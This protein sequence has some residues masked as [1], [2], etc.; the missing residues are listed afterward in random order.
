MRSSLARTAC[1]LL[2]A[3]GGAAVA[4]QLEVAPIMLDLPP[5][6]A[7][8]VL[9]VKNRGGEPVGIQVR[10]FAW[11]QAVENDN[12]DPHQGLADQSGPSRSSH[13]AKRKQYASS[14]ANRLTGRK[15]AIGCWSMSSRRPAWPASS[16]WPC[17]YPC[18]CSLR[19]PDRVP[20]TCNGASC[21]RPHGTE[22]QAINR[23]TKRERVSDMA[24]QVAGLGTVKPQP[25]TNAWVLA[26]AERHWL[27]PSVRP[28]DV[29]RV[30]GE[31][32]REARIGRDQCDSPGAS[33]AVA[34]PV[35]TS[36]PPCWRSAC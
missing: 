4:G 17:G 35:S 21:R 14:C 27:I 13:R 7:S 5:G 31:P 11:S 30:A 34:T 23:G 22:L 24:L 25:L 29:P 15:Q 36:P 3:Q 12:P 26:G 9:T 10:G 16:S 1:A 6:V 18:R 19:P 28:G 2:V 8:T 33:R 20:R 32:E